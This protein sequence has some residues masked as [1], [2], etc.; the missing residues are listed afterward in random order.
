MKKVRS[1]ADD[2]DEYVKHFSEYVKREPRNVGTED[3]V[4]PGDEW[5]TPYEWATYADKFLNPFLPD[6]LTGIA[7]EIGP[8]SGKYTMKVIDK[9][10]R[11]ICY[12][13]SEQFIKIAQDRLSRYI[14]AGKVE[15]ELLKLTNC[16]EIINSLRAKSL[17]GKVDLFFSVDSMVHVELHTLIAYLIN[18]AKALRLGGFLAMGVASCT[19]EGGFARLL[20]ETPWCYGGMRPSHQFYFLSKDIVRFILDKL[21]FELVLLDEIRDVNFVAKKIKD[22]PI[23]LL[24][25]I[26]EKPLITVV[27]CTYQRPIFLRECLKSVLA[28]TYDHY[29]VIVVGQGADQ[30]SQRI[31]EEF[32][33]N[34]ANVQYVH[35]ETVGLSPARNVGCR[36][37]R[38]EIIAFIDDDAVASPQWLEGYVE[39]FQETFPIP[40]MV[41]G[42]IEP[43]W[44]TPK[45]KWYPVGREFL[46]GLYNIGD[47]AR[48]FPET[49]LPVGANFAILRKAI[50]GLD[51]FDERLGFNIKRKHS[52]IAGEDSL[53]ALRVK[54]VGYP[55]YYQPKAKV[56]HHVSSAKLSRKYFLR[57]HYWEG[58][59]HV[60]VESYRG[61]QDRARYRGV[62]L[63]HSM[64]ILRKTAAILKVFFSRKKGKDC[65]MMLKL[66]ELAVS[67]GA[68]KK[69]ID[70]MIRK[71]GP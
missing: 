33:E 2:W 27:I 52:M 32:L 4:Y 45:P 65:Q 48:L 22:V 30:A 66:S 26:G 39:I 31:V 63:L 60:A 29:E 19:N 57:R 10:K 71:P 49:D 38:G 3:L 43:L 69:S 64:K 47:E 18:A 42:R 9:T 14:A 36:H 17:L 40:G 61:V 46:L 53:V 15:F 21:G 11:M 56:Y 24:T 23:G 59:T 12:D 50:D 70:L 20:D 55:I 51:G 44:E 5:G 13:V 25:M 6:D 28:N 1:Y 35:S 67:L 54:D 41:G 68:C 8:G 37:A 62:L 58:V 7:V 16:S 34:H